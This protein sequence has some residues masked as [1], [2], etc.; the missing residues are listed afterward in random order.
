MVEIIHKAAGVII[1][2]RR[3]LVGRSFGKDVFISPGGKV[4][5][6][7]SDAECLI[8]ELKEEYGI[9]VHLPDL[10]DF[11]AFSA[12]AA[13]DEGRQVFIQVFLVTNYKGELTPSGEVEE[14]R[15][16]STDDM[17]DIRLGSVFKDD[18]IPKL[19]SLDLID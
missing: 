15:F 13:G 8:R 19:K 1:K 14:M 12:P 16:I 6:R 3:L 17:K 11:G 2:D 9:E 7:E 18:V 4:Q 5:E 10:V